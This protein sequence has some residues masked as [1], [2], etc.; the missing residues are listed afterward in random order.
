MIA[1]KPFDPLVDL[2]VLLEVST[3]GKTHITK[4][5]LEGPHVSVAPHMGGKL[6]QSQ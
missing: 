4:V 6:T 5:A 3:L 2:S 1:G